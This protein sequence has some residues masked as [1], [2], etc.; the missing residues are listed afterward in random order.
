MS[1]EA[2][3][4]KAKGN[5]CVGADPAQAIEHYTKAI[6]LDATDHTFFSNRS[7]AHM[8][9]GN[10]AEALNDATSCVSMKPDWPKVRRQWFGV[11][12][13]RC[14]RARV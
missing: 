2:K 9:T 3:E 14:R 7:A 6:E 10:F 13:R 1:A 12:R 8:K 11:G 5:A 4:W